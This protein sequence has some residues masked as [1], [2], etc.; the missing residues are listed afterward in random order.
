[1]MMVKDNSYK[2]I[3]DI[4]KEV[5]PNLKLTKK[6]YTV[7]EQLISGKTEEKLQQ[8]ID[9]VS[10]NKNGRYKQYSFDRTKLNLINLALYHSKIIDLHSILDEIECDYCKRSEFTNLLQAVRKASNEVYDFTRTRYA[11][12]PDNKIIKNMNSKRV[13]LFELKTKGA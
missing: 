2:S 13:P 4:I 9:M 3:K 6:E 1:M 5:R 12:K 8:Y 11:N 10:R 7:I